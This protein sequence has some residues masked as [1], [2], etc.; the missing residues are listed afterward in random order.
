MKYVYNSILVCSLAL[1]CNTPAL[2]QQ[3]VE[4]GGTVRTDVGDVLPGAT[5]F[6]K[7]TFVGTSTNS[8]GA[9]RLA[10]SPTSSPVTLSVSFVGYETQQVPLTDLNAR[11]DIVLVPAP[12]PISQVVA[13]A[14]RVEERIAQA[15]VTV[16]K[17]TADYIQR[18]PSPDLLRGLSQLKSIDANAAGVLASSVSTRGFNSPTSERLIQLTD[19][20]D[21]QAP[22]LS[23]S[24]GNVSGLPELDVASVEVIQGPSS[25]LYGANA[26]N[27]VLLLNSKDSTLR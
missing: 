1:G 22:S 12:T 16:E 20:F 3:L 18:L 5:V 6:L 10:V 14:S 25:A 15:P 13:S 26:F 11:L 7:G 17:A 19:Y 23:T 9:F 24:L 27:G 8:T 4:L 21:T 2:A